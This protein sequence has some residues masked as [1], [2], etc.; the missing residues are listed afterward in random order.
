MLP[1]GKR[2]TLVSVWY[3]Q[4]TLA[5]V[6][7]VSKMVTVMMMSCLFVGDA[8]AGGGRCAGSFD[9]WQTTAAGERGSLEIYTRGTV[10]SACFRS[11]LVS[12]GQCCFFDGRQAYMYTTEAYL[13]NERILGPLQVVLQVTMLLQECPIC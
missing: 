4:V 8:D 13:H 3:M 5:G 12:S 6:S 1:E 2:S 10:G 7:A 11:C 9:A